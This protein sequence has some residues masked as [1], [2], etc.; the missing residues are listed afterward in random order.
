M[1]AKIVVFRP[2]A[3]LVSVKSVFLVTGS[4]DVEFGVSPGAGGGGGHHVLL[5]P[6]GAVSLVTGARIHHSDPPRPC[7]SD[8][9]QP[10]K[11]VA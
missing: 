10:L 6:P 7:V 2:E 1:E 9:L 3:S 4:T 5:L 8:R 11:I